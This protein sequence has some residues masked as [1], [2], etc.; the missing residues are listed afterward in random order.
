MTSRSRLLGAARSLASAALVL[1]TACFT[2][3]SPRR[4][5]LVH[6]RQGETVTVHLSTGYA[7]EGELIGTSD[8]T[9]VLMVGERVVVGKFVEIRGVTLRSTPWRSY[10]PGTREAAEPLAR[11]SRFAFGVTDAALAALLAQSKQSTPEPLVIPP[12]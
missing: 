4:A 1:C 7:R 2:S 12:Q 10:R 9:L 5:A 11:A 8:S 3:P 6:S